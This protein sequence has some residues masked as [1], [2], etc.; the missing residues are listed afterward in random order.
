MEQGRLLTKLADGTIRQVNP[1]T[2]TEVL[3]IPGRSERPAVNNVP[4]PQKVEKRNPE[5]Y[6]DL[7]E[8]KYFNTPPEK[9]RLI[10]KDSGYVSMKD[11][12]AGELSLSQPLFRRIPN[13]FEIFT[14]DYWREN[15]GTTLSHENELRKKRYLADNDSRHHLLNV[16]D[17]K[18]TRTGRDPSSVDEKQKLAMADAFFGGGH[19]LIVAGKHY[20]GESWPIP[21]LYSSGEMSPEEHF[22]FFKFTISGMA[23]CYD[24]NP[25]VRYVVVF[26]NWLR[27]AGASF[28]HLHK[29]IVAADRHGPVIEQML[30]AARRNPDIFSELGPVMARELR[31]LI[32]E[33]EHALA[34][35]DIGHIYPT[36]T[37]QSKSRTCDPCRF[38]DDELRGM[39]DLVHS[40]HR[41]IGGSTSCN[42]E[43]YYAPRGAGISMPWRISI[44]QRINT[45]AGF[46]GV[47]GTY[48]IPID[49]INL[50]KQLL[51]RLPGCV[52]P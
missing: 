8:G 2:G 30:N 32:A 36:V 50:R 52:V 33:N 43:W 27:P 10:P 49:P 26:Q 31:L 24:V 25:A 11:L 40:V 41:A 1:F 29:Q 51:L 21:R 5:D 44:K 28:D 46:E 45:P 38:N 34:F 3:T 4:S 20:V 47:T 18:L 48:I 9:E 35:A 19:E 42:E 7:C 23:A 14:Y 37:I 39:S 22:H 12:S 17:L 15:F 16:I 13:L 6:C